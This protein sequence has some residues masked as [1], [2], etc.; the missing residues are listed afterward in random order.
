MTILPEFLSVILRI[1]GMEQ[2]VVNC[3]LDGTVAGLEIAGV[4]GHRERANTDISA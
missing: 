4:S 1:V 2:R 3:A